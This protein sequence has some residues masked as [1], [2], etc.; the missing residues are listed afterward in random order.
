VALI[1]PRPLRVRTDPSWRR[2][3]GPP[4][5]GKVVIAGSP[6]R[7]FRLSAGGA[8]V[9]A[10]AE[11][12][13]V[14][15]TPSIRSLVDRFIDAGALHPLPEG[16]PF[17]PDD[18]TVV[19]PAYGSL[20]LA[21]GSPALDGLRTV[22]VD[23]TSAVP[24]IA[25]LPVTLVRRSVNGGPA[26]ARN[27]G[28]DA[29]T[30]PLV[31]FVDA[32]VTLPDGWLA[33]LLA[34]F[35]DERVALVAPRV[36]GAPGAGALAAYEQR[37]SPLDL[38]PDPARIAAG[39]RVSYVPAAVLV[40]R[41]SVLRELGGFD[42]T[43]RL[44]EDV[45]LVWRLTEA[46]H[47]CRYEPAVV[48][49]HEPRRTVCGLL[50]QRFGYGHSA[51]SLAARHPGAL[52]PVR[53]SGWSALAWG[54]LVLR[55]PVL[56]A[57]VAAGTTA[58]LVRKLADVPP[59]E[60]IRL[61]GRGHLAAGRQLARAVTRVWWPIALLAALVRRRARGPVLA[62]F[63]AEAFA[64]AI[65][66]RSLQP[67]LDAPLA[68]ADDAAYGA[69]VWAGAV[70]ERRPGPLLPEFRNWPTPTPRPAGG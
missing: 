60:A 43:M 36:A 3:T 58:A 16:G 65:G 56:A 67:V 44:G 57:G 25:P 8:H 34:H 4:A 2:P 7:L 9:I 28:L 19:L 37:H 10:Q 23:D 31:A 39:T 66:Q 63:A 51:A 20:P 21:L 32:D 38:G 5:E 24:L 61:A 26:A 22:M 49:L 59:A 35:A 1:P 42:T 55:R 54:L 46:G 18:V 27:D 41:A 14:P 17:T 33:P 52:A 64:G 70:A 47:R 62:A 53:M 11:A 13:E 29:V 69:G 50:G 12:G 6:L 40:C 45:D 68:L 48:A 30:T 15:D